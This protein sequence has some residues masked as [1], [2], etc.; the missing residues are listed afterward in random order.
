TATTTP[1]PSW[2]PCATSSRTGP[3]AHGSWTRSCTTTPGRCTG[4]R[5]PRAGALRGAV[6]QV[7]RLPRVQVRRRVGLDMDAGGAGE[8]V[9]AP[10]ARRLLDLVAVGAQARGELV[11]LGVGRDVEGEVVQDAAAVAVRRHGAVDGVQ[12]ELVVAQRVGREEH[13][14]ARGAVHAAQTEHVLPEIAL[15]LE[16]LPRHVE[17]DV[18][19]PYQRCHGPPP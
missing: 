1:R 15:L 8:L 14:P 6:R 16:E 4:C 13:V 12:D 2:R 7:A 3:S 11:D 17:P 19:E 5:H 10:V 18:A 9:L